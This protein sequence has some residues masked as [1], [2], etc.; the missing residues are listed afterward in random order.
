MDDETTQTSEI[1]RTDDIR[2]FNKHRLLNFLRDNG[3]ATYAE[4]REKVGENSAR[5]LWRLVKA[6]KVQQQMPKNGDIRYFALV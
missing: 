4:V 3:G 6:R 1:V 2:P 5:E